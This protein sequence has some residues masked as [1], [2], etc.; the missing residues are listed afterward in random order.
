MV[1]AH[2]QKSNSLPPGHL[3]V[4]FLTLQIYHEQ[5]C[6]NV[7]S[8][9]I[10]SETHESEEVNGTKQHSQIDKCCDG[11]NTKRCLRRIIISIRLRKCIE[12]CAHFDIR[13][14]VDSVIFGM[15]YM[16][17]SSLHC[18][19]SAHKLINFHCKSPLLYIIFIQNLIGRSR[20]DVALSRNGMSSYWFITTH[21]SS[22]ERA[23]RRDAFFSFRAHA[24][25]ANLCN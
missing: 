23:Q 20:L 13:C 10:S 18:F 3:V 25:C 16:L 21:H 15:L 17:I 22:H 2:T 19:R 1:A 5:L 6:L 7:I 11:F 12:R 14:V 4:N 24:A 8:V 9:S